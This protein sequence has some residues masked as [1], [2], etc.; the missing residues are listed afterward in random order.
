MPVVATDPF[1]TPAAGRPAQDA[2]AEDGF[3]VVPSDTDELEQV[4][5]QLWVRGAGDLTVV[6][7]SGRTK[8]Y[9]AVAA[10]ERLNIRVKQVKASGTTATNI[11]AFV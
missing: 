11:E 9:L 5:R 8:T 4:T 3:A 10:G 6:F 1:N 2:S 7:K